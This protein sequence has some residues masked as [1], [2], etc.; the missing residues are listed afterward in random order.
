[1]SNNL[2]IKPLLP[3][4]R[5]KKRYIAYK[6]IAD[7]KLSQKDIENAIYGKT[8]EM[9][10]TIGLSDIGIMF[11]KEKFNAEKQAGF[12]KVN[13]NKINQIRS[14]F[15]FIES[16]NNEKA[17]VECITASGSMKKI[18]IEVL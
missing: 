5:Q 15:P 12:F 14:V 3:T 17:V 16:I 4:L 6:V 2:K 18:G 1:M 8:K 7:K 13:H 11:F 10:G 9:Y